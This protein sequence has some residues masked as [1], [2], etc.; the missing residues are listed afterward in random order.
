MLRP[1]KTQ[2]D[3]LKALSWTTPSFSF[4]GKHF[5]TVGAELEPKPDRRIPIWLGT[6][7]DRALELT[8]RVADGWIPSYPY[9][10]PEVVGEKMARVRRAAEVSQPVT[11]VPARTEIRRSRPFSH[12]AAI[13][14]GSCAN[15]TP[16]ANEPPVA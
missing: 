11:Y 6:Y 7:G 2:R 10:P 16:K 5:W 4:Q 1:T 14:G 15:P 12:S 8:G 13:V 9:A 3:W